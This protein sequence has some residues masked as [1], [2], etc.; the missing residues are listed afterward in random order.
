MNI[1]EDIK[2]LTEFKRDT[3]HF[4]AQL[5]KSGRPSILTVNGRPSLVVMDATAWQAREDRMDSAWT[6]S[7]LRAG[8][9][10]ADVGEG[11][12]AELFFASLDNAD[13]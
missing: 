3:A 7:E 10:Q 13:G 9:A 4:I 6:R 11:A 8:L 5:K 12:D 1:T 2:S